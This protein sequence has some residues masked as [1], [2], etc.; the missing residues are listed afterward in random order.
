MSPP[1]WAEI[2]L[3]TSKNASTN[4]PGGGGV[5]ARESERDRRGGD[6]A[7]V[8]HFL[9]QPSLLRILKWGR[10]RRLPPLLGLFLELPWSRAI[11]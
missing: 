6:G 4:P 11:L 9:A 2:N 7:G 1:I 8:L 5:G 3:H 10:H